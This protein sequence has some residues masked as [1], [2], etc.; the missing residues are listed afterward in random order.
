MPTH[1]IIFNLLIW[2]YTIISFSYI[3][4]G[5]IL[6]ELARTQTPVTPPTTIVVQ[7]AVQPVVMP[8][9]SKVTL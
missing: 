6:G 4:A 9:P 2:N 7:P 5:G 8:Q 3:C 1:Q